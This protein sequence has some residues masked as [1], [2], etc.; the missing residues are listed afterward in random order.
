MKKLFII[1]FISLIL[2]ACATTQRP[3]LYQIHKDVKTT[4][5][6]LQEKEKN[7]T[8]TEEEKKALAELKGLGEK[9]EIKNLLKYVDRDIDSSDIITFGTASQYGYT[10]EEI[11]RFLNLGL[12]VKN[13]YCENEYNSYEI[14][15]VLSDFVLASGC[16]VTSYSTCST[17]N[18]KIFVYP[19]QEE[20]LYFDKKILTPPS[21]FCSTYV[22]VFTY[23]S[24]DGASHTVPVLTFLPKTISKQQ[25]EKVLKSREE[26]SK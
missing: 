16:E 12:F 19:K 23:E 14:F 20:E 18:S 6:N 4:I 7:T 15:Q 1:I 24:K 8:L 10:D 11:D 17:I 22:G 13:P 5:K 21:E 9:A 3:S 2:C 25:L 26:F